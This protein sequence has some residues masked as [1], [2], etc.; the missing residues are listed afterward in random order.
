MREA[1]IR[2]T[3]KNRV[4]GH[5]CRDS[6]KIEVRE[7]F[8]ETK[9]QAQLAQQSKKQKAQSKSE[10]KAK[11]KQAKAKADSKA[12]TTGQWARLAGEHSRQQDV[13]RNWRF[14]L[15]HYSLSFSSM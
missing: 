11:D 14:A 1:L 9:E 2:D 13:P 15:F 5:I 3:Q 4:V 7:R 6:T 12:K 8:P 10:R